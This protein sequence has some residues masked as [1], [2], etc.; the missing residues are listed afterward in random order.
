[1]EMP[2][3]ND[4]NVDFINPGWKGKILPDLRIKRR[5]TSKRHPTVFS[6]SDIFG[7]MEICSR[8]G[9]LSH[10]GLNM[11]PGQEANGNILGKSF[12]SSTQ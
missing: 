12:R 5:K 10:L 7:I 3:F 8:H 6:G 2:Q 11:T 1:M 9:Y 4:G